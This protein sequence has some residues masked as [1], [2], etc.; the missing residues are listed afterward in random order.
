MKVE[1]LLF[2]SCCGGIST[3]LKINKSISL[4][5]LEYFKINNFKENPSFTKS[6]ILY[7]ENEDVILTGAIGSNQI[8]IKCRNKNCET[9][10]ATVTTYLEAYNE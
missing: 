10:I 2:K 1:K 9:V 4:K 3:V 6:G 7:I 8:Q 5:L